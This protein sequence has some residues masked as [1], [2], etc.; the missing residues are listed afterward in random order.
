MGK[1]VHKFFFPWLYKQSFE[2]EVKAFFNENILPKLCQ[3]IL[4]TF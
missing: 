3:R 2:D 1:N 4:I